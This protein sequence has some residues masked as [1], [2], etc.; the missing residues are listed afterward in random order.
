L[1]IASLSVPAAASGPTPEA[2]DG[3]D[4]ATADMFAALMAGFMAPAVT[5]DQAAPV[6]NVEAASG[7][8]APVAPAVD[9]VNPFV[10]IDAMPASAPAKVDIAL[11]RLGR[12]F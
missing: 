7:T 11:D 5:P 9:G 1:N 12:K 8:I 6:P 2:A 4:P 3:T 10:T